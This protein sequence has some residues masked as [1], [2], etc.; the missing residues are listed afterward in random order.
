M[1]SKLPLA[2][3]TSYYAISLSANIIL[4]LLIIGRLVAYR[5]TLLQSLPADLANHYISLATVIVESAALYSIFAILFL[6]TY[7]V[8]NPTNQIWLGV[9]SACQVRFFPPLLP[10]AILICL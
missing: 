2:Y 10:L 7:A 3:G 8:N 4:T 6:I 5:R 1:Y 9:A